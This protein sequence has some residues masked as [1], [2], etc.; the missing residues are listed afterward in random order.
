VISVNL[1]DVKKDENQEKWEPYYNYGVTS[2]DYQII[3]ER[4]A[5][6]LPPDKLEVKVTLDKK[7]YQPG[8]TVNY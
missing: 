6:I 3:A 5:F 4:L 2:F 7:S 1:Y 8:D